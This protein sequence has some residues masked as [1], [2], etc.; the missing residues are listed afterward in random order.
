M[1]SLQQIIA[2][3]QLSPDLIDAHKERVVRI[4]REAEQR[5]RIKA[6]P[7]KP[8]NI[9]NAKGLVTL[10]E[11][12]RIYGT[13]CTNTM[14]A[15]IRQ[16]SL[17]PIMVQKMITEFR[18]EMLAKG[19]TYADFARAFHTYLRKGYLSKRLSGCTLERSPFTHRVVVDTKGVNL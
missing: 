7:N 13:L 3:I 17:C 14:P 2:E 6:A 5:L 12:E 18:D 16:N 11:W 8:R 9:K 15:W 19:K 1:P 10:D 4:I